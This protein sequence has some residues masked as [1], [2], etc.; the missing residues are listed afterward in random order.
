MATAPPSG[1]PNIPDIQNNPGGYN[2]KIQ[3]A[4]CATLKSKGGNGNSYT[5]EEKKI[6][7]LV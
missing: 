2:E 6:Y 5:D 3:K 7:D 4:V 1:G